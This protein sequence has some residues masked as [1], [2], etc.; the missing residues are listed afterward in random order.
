M[1]LLVDSTS[2]SCRPIIP[3]AIYIIKKKF[4]CRVA[5]SEDNEQNGALPNADSNIN[6]PELESAQDHTSPSD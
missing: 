5:N 3:E 6:L 4:Y 1:H 2:L